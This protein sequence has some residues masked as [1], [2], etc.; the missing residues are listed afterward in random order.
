MQKL[1]IFSPATLIFLPSKI[2]GISKAPTLVGVV[3]FW[4]LDTTI[5]V[6]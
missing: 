1:R 5:S 4:D 3:V 6:Y 2:L